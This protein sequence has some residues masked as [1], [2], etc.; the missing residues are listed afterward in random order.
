MRQ[1]LR[2]NSLYCAAQLIVQ[3]HCGTCLALLNC[4]LS[5]QKRYKGSEILI[6]LTIHTFPLIPANACFQTMLTVFKLFTEDWM[7]KKSISFPFL[8]SSPSSLRGLL[9]PLDPK[10]IVK[11]GSYQWTSRPKPHLSKRERKIIIRFHFRHPYHLI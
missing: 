10:Y 4:M 9:L 2:N 6:S 3:H 11:G 7:C 1:H 8:P 5:V